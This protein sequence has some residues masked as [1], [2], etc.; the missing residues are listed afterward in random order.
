MKLNNI[1][2]VRKYNMDR[3]YICM[4]NDHLVAAVV[5]DLTWRRPGMPLILL[6]RASSLCLRGYIYANDQIG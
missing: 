4:D 1:R 6:L 5:G 2:Y 3:I